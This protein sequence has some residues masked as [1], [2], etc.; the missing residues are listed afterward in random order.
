MDKP[1]QLG[2]EELE[3][4]NDL[5][6]PDFDLLK[7]VIL[8]AKKKHSDDIQ[9]WFY[10]IRSEWTKFPHRHHIYGL[11]PLA[12][13]HFNPDKSLGYRLMQRLMPV[14]MPMSHTF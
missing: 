14:M 10:S 1:I 9:S 7:N 2:P 5:S 4:I 3:L 12:H 6:H 13:I 8:F 11:D